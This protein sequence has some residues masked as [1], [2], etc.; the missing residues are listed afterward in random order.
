MLAP[1]LNLDKLKHLLDALSLPAKS[2]KLNLTP[3][4]LT[5]NTEWLLLDWGFE[6]VAATRR[7]LL[8]FFNHSKRSLELNTECSDRPVDKKI[9]FFSIV[10]SKTH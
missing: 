4:Q 1:S 5:E 6:R 7:L 8:P 9:L 10:S 3:S 2:I